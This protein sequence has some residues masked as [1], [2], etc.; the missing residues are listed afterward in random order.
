MQAR[1]PTSSTSRQTASS[2]SAR[3]SSS[4]GRGPLPSEAKPCGRDPPMPANVKLSS[5]DAIIL[6]KSRGSRAGGPARGLMKS[7]LRS[8]IAKGQ[9]IRNGQDTL[10]YRPLRSSAF[11]EYR[12]RQYPHC[13]DLSV[14]C[15]QSPHPYWVILWQRNRRLVRRRGHDICDQ[16]LVREGI[17]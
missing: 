14:R 4:E 12:L 5:R 11:A 8:F 7:A 3:A 1:R 13:V 10:P 15:L 17:G 16:I 2:S 6:R 9:E